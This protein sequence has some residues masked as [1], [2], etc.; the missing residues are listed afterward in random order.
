[1]DFEVAGIPFIPALLGLVLAGHGYRKKSLSP[2]GALTAFV[3]G[4]IMIAVPLRTFGLAL[5]SF[6]LI[7]SR[8]TK[9]GKRQKAQL[10]EGHQEAGYRS[11]M[12][13]MCNAFSAFIASLLWSAFFVQNS[14]TSVALEQLYP[15]AISLERPYASQEWC[16]LSRDVGGGWSRRLVFA[17]LGYVP[18]VCLRG[19][20]DSFILPLA[21]TLDVASVIPLL[22]NSAFSLRALRI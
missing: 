12:Q 2:S 4:S 14:F 3:V 6:Y 7:G 22:P 16:V 9:V 15:D 10:E 13:V 19:V 11:G 17:T 20:A 8:A 5:V 1:M 21:G 18:E